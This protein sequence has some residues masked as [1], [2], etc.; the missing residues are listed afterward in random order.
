MLISWSG[1]TAA[2]AR[3]V[4]VHGQREGDAVRLLS[5]TTLY[6]VLPRSDPLIKHGLIRNC[7]ELAAVAGSRARGPRASTHPY[8][9]ASAIRLH[10]SPS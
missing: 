6:T 5:L 4:L 10:P 9:D 8:D 7:S 2:S 3:T 1:S